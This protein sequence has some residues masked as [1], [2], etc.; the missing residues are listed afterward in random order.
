M[1]LVKIQ[2][3]ASGTGEFTIAAPNSNTNRTLTLPDNTGTILTSAT[4]GSVL[5][6][7]SATKTDTFSTAS[8]SLVDITG[9]SVSITPTS[10]TSNI[11]I[12]AVVLGAGAE[13]VTGI[14]FVLLRDSTAIARGDAAGSRS[15]G[16]GGTQEIVDGLKT[17]AVNFLDSPATTSATTYKIQASVNSG[18]G[19]VNRTPDDDDGSY[20]VRGVSTI[21]VMEIAA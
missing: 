6:V 7:V 10:A 13:S 11:L 12:T 19:Y 14:N 1:S 17:N 2:G 20:T 16:F 4:A 21:T 9:L 5:Q 3:N 8:T 15:R 18:T